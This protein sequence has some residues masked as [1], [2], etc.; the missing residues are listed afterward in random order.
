MDGTRLVTQRQ[1]A[2]LAAH[3]PAQVHVV[4]D[5]P[6]VRA[7]LARLLRSRGYDVACHPSAE[8]F[9]AGHDPDS[10]GCILLDVSMPGLDGPALQRKLLEDGD[11]MPIIFLTGCA[12]VP[13]C[14]TAMRNGAVDFLTK[15]VDEDEL[16]R[17]ITLALEHDAVRRLARGHQEMTETRL[18]SLTPR[19]REVLDHVMNGRLNKQIASDLGTAEKTVKVHRARA[20]E[21]MSV[22]SVAELVRM[23]E[24]ARL[25]A[26]WFG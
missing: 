26:P 21:K 9:L 11:A 15:P 24:R 4:D 10:H 3:D 17:S 20:M 23:V 25:G 6:A 5:D 22:R 13:L 1:P 7:A 12:D 18:S 19:E 14:A 8:S 16:V 2:S